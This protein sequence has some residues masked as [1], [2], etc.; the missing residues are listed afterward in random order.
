M[1][2]RRRYLASYA[3]LIRLRST[4]WECAGHAACSVALWAFGRAREAG[5]CSSIVAGRARAMQETES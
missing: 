1:N 5:E 3:G 2:V 4:A